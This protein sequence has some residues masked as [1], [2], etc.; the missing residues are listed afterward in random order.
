MGVPV[1]HRRAEQQAGPVDQLVVRR[2]LNPG[3]ELGGPAVLCAQ[4]DGLTVELGAGDREAQLPGSSLA[5]AG[6]TYSR[7]SMTTFAVRSRPSRYSAIVSA[8]LETP[9]ARLSIVQTA[10]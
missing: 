3:A 4:A 2:R 8:F 10:A 5:S 1:D 7:S 6:S 9:L